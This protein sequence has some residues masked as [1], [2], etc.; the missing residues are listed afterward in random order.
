MLLLKAHWRWLQELSQDSSQVKDDAAI[1]LHFYL[2]LTCSHWSQE[3]VA[4]AISSSTQRPD[5]Q[6]ISGFMHNQFIFAKAQHRA[7]LAGLRAP[8]VSCLSICTRLTSLNMWEWRR[9]W[10]SAFPITRVTS[11][12][13]P[14]KDIGKHCWKQLTEVAGKRCLVIPIPIAILK[15]PLIPNCPNSQAV[16]SPI[17]AATTELR[18]GRKTW[19]KTQLWGRES[20]GQRAYGKPKFHALWKPK[21]QVPSLKIATKRLTHTKHRNQSPSFSRIKRIKWN[22][23]LAVSPVGAEHVQP[24]VTS[25]TLT[26]RVLF[27]FGKRMEGMLRQIVSARYFFRMRGLKTPKLPRDLLFQPLY[28]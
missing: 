24:H 13:K 10:H 6:L 17:T 2:L 25:W 15:T 16:C 9:P 22:L 14:A 4:R 7:Q 12:A 3:S 18:A 27:C 5:R 21:S 11:V 23:N 20:H 19:C 1:H 8:E 28:V 26:E